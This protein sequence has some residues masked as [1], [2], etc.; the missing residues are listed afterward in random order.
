MKL[1]QAFIF[2]A[3]RGER[4]RPITDS[5][6]KPLVKIKGKAIIDYTIEK[7]LR[8]SSLEKIIINGFY[9]SEQ[10][11]EHIRNWREPRLVFS[12]ETSKVE[13]G[14]GLVFAGGLI[15]YSKPLLCANGD[16]LWEDLVGKS[17]VEL[18]VEAYGNRPCDILLGLKKVENYAGYEG[19][20]DFNLSGCALLKAPLPLSHAFVGLQII[21]PKILQKAPSQCFSMSHFYKEAVGAN[22]VLKGVEGVELDGRF[23]HIGTVDSIKKTED[24]L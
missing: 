3:G 24:L 8:I 5:L 15:D 23:F 9:L 16:V 11:E 10:V 22:G 2:A 7:F 21:D 1:T 14:G 17:D 20:G 12:R 19:E 6:P 4:M 13:T 18:M